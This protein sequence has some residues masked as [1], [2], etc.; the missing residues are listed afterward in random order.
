VNAIC[1]NSRTETLSAPKLLTESGNAT[2][3]RIELIKQYYFPDEWEEYE[4]DADDGGLTITP[5]R[6][7]FEDPTDVGIIFDVSARVSPDEQGTINLKLDPQIIQYVSNDTYD[8]NI[9]GR[10]IDAQGNENERNF[11]YSVWMPVFSERILSVNV[12]VYDGCTLVLGGIVQNQ[13]SS[14]VDK[15]PFFGDLP[16]IGRFFQSRAEVGKKT[17]M[18]MFVTARLVGTD[19]IPLKQYPEQ[20]IPDF[21]R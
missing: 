2:P 6:P 4:L 21:L 15:W 9:Y 18:M 20:G 1:Q 19:G 12:K 3:A 5:P 17:N 8:I 14:R 10:E 11:H 16:L 7:S 13:M